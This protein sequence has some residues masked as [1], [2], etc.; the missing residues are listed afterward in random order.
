MTPA[1]CELLDYLKALTEG[2]RPGQFVDVR[3]ARADGGM[4]QHF[5]PAQ[6]IDR[7]AR[8][9]TSMAW[10]TDVFVGVALRD[11]DTHGGKSAISGSRLLYIESDHHDSEA[12]L[13]GFACAPSMV[14]ASGSPGHLHLYWFLDKPAGI[15]EVEAANRRIAV[16]LDGDLA[17]VDIAR[18]LRPP[19]S[20]NHK[21]TPPRPVRL[22]HL[23]TTLHFQL[24]ELTQ[25]LPP[26][27]EPSTPPAACVQSRRRPRNTL[28]RALLAVPAAEYARVLADREANRAGKI[29]CPFHEETDPSLKLY[30][31]G[32]FYC[33][34][35]GCRKG[36][37]IFDFAAAIW[38]IGTKNEDFHELR[39]RLAS[40]FLHT[41]S[42][43][44]PR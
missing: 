11:S 1:S 44:S 39:R 27:P 16:A 18:V 31:D 7:A 10:R 6:R 12:R 19:A 37:T 25:R 21:H 14:V 30:P 43:R 41:P 8:L 23:D 42:P 33:F 29:L 36:G 22:L 17:S 3:C 9:I 26:D 28:D 5:V 32:S 15:L 20:M 13:H 24:G 4:R 34:G 40:L 2:R 35:R 38:G